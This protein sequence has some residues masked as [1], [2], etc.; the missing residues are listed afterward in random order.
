MMLVLTRRSR[1]SV[2]VA[3]SNMA[4]ELLKVTVLEIKRGRVV[5]GIEGD[6]N[7]PV[8]RSE[9]WDRIC[10]RKETCQPMCCEFA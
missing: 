10:A 9:V 4:E 7:I 1:E 3:S 2:I 5:L 8:F 6:R